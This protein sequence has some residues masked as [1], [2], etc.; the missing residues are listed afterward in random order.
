[1]KILLLKNIWG[2]N[3]RETLKEVILDFRVGIIIAWV[4]VEPTLDDL[5]PLTLPACS[6][7][8]QLSYFLY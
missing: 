5:T 1:M 6:T 4:G 7:N 3:H 2:L 8:N